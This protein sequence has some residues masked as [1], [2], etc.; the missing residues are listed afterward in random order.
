M[1]KLV[2]TTLLGVYRV[3]NASGI[4]RTGPG[5]SLFEWGYHR[6]KKLFEAGDIRAL[7]SLVKPATVVIDVGANIGF[8]T[9]FFADSVSAGGKVLAIEPEQTNFRRLNQMIKKNRL[10]E[11]VE[12]FEA[13]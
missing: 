11:L 12:T 2:Q 6:Y 9:K 7:A 3:V 13:V 4:L 1:K 5:R 10:K 8:F